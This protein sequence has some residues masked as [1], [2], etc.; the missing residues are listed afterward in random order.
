MRKDNDKEREEK[1]LSAIGNLPE[2]MIVQAAGYRRPSHRRVW[3]LLGK[4]LVVAA[5]AALVVFGGTKG[6]SYVQ[7]CVDEEKGVQIEKETVIEKASSSVQQQESSMGMEK[8][9]GGVDSAE[10]EGMEDKDTD[11]SKKGAV[12]A[13][14]IQLWTVGAAVSDSEKEQG[15]QSN[16]TKQS[17]YIDGAMSKILLEEG[18]TVAL[19]TTQTEG[20]EG[21]ELSVITVHFAE[22]VNDVTYS[23]RS[24]LSNCKIVTITHNG[25]TKYV[26]QA[27]AEC[28]GGDAVELDTRLSS[29]AS[30]A[31]SIVPEW[32][33]IVV[34]DIVDITGKEE[35]GEE[36]EMGR[37]VIGR[38]FDEEQLRKQSSQ[39]GERYYGIYQN[40]TD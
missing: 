6:I 4:G 31:D 39:E 38:Q 2:D 19:Q 17:G 28:V 5:C 30:W 35:S 22:T 36:F 15:S 9:S 34:M 37:L 7:N 11:S 3:N 23:L 24:Q 29:L 13:P 27:N 40:K 1:L 16:K 33:D 26:N 12:S 14:E 21:E 18:K 32:K 8:R 25:L 10:K 20:S